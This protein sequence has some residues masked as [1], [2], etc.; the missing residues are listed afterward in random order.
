[1]PRALYAA[2]T[3]SLLLALGV[4]GWDV[5]AEWRSSPA[6]VA[7]QIVLPARDGIVAVDPATGRA[8]EIVRSGQS[9]TITS[10][11]WSPDRG[12]VAYGVFHRVAGDQI[13][14]GEIF[15]APA[16]G[17]QG[18]TLVA[19]DRPGSVADTP[20]WSADGQYLYFGYQGLEGRQPIARVERLRLADGTRTS[21]FEDAITPDISPDGRSVAFIRDDPGG[22]SLAVG[23]ADGGGERELI[24]RTAFTAMMAPRFSP[25]GTRIAF[26]AV[27]V[28]PSGRIG[29]FLDTLGSL[30]SVPVA[31]A[32]GEPW[33][34]WSVRVDGTDLRRVTPLTED[35]PLV[36][37][38]ADGSWL[39]VHGMGGLWVVAANGTVEPRRVAEGTFGAIDW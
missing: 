38:S 15:V 4:L 6:A 13:S 9:Q 1:M 34:I 37:W 5:W 36:A 7:G 20:R 29:G 19:R 22:Q 39:A 35:E 10:A 27:G 24:A 12:R 14:S 11:A 8:R 30:F 17:G 2:C 21:L 23:S 26:T 28:G 31:Y 25:D 3:V 32:H 16:G 33:G 18:E